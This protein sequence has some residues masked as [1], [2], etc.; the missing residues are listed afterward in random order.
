MKKNVF[1]ILFF[2]SILISAK[3]QNK[4]HIKGEFIV[5]TTENYLKKFLKSNST[6]FQIKKTIS[7]EI[8]IY[9]ISTNSILDE[10]VLLNQLHENPLIE[11]A[12]FNH[13]VQM[14]STIPNDPNYSNQWHY[15]N[16]GTNGGSIGADLDMDLAWDKAVGGNTP[17]GDTIVICVIDDGID[18]NHLDFTSNIW[19][20]HQE[21]PNNGIDDDN[22]G[23]IDDYRGWN[24]SSN[25]DSIFG[26]GHG[27]PVSGVIGAK[28]NNNEGIAGINWNVKLMIVKNDF[29]TDEA[30]VLEAYNYPLVMRKL[31]NQSNGAKGAFIVAT[32]SSWGINYG[33]PDDSPLWCAMYDSLGKYGIIS[34]GATANLN[35]DVELQNDM[36]TGCKSDFLISVT[37][38]NNADIKVTSAAYGSKSID[39]GAY[40]E[41]IYTTLFGNSY[42]SSSG[43]SIATPMVAGSIGL[44][45]AL[46]CG[47]F[48]QIS[49]DNPEKAALLV[50]NAILSSVVLNASLMGK[51]LTN[52]R[53]NVNNAVNYAVNN[54][55]NDVCLAPYSLFSTSVSDTTA[56]LH[57]NTSNDT[58]V[59][60]RYK[61]ALDSIWIEITS[62]QNYLQLSNLKPCQNYEFQVKMACPSGWSNYSA[63]ST[64][65]TEGC[66]NCLSTNY[67]NS[68]ASSSNFA[69]IDSVGF[70]SLSKM[71]LLNNGYSNFLT[72]DS[73]FYKNK[74]YLLTIK[75]GFSSIEYKAFYKA[76]IDFNQNNIFDS[77][78]L[79]FENLDG[80]SLTVSD[81]VL[82]PESALIGATRMRI[83]MQIF[84]N[85]FN[86][87]SSL[88]FGEVEDFCIGIDT[89]QKVQSVVYTEKSNIKVFPN[90][91]TNQFTISLNSKQKSNI[92][93]TDISGKILFS[94]NYYSKNISVEI[95]NN[96][97]KGVYFV[98]IELPQEVF[99]HKIIKN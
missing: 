23:Y 39:L 35:I 31:Y 60:I 7:K 76:W 82:I 1:L 21:I 48:A 26:G 14:R 56:M 65:R 43:T 38:L 27:T 73:R 5:K 97:S 58:I 6:H 17:L 22:N 2:W 55:D 12:Q 16:D 90:P 63:V 57:W 20:N 91:F 30:A 59:E 13:K 80:D 89:V 68:K 84:S 36:P 72:L 83:S 70:D 25:S 77:T 28:G 94:S 87:C 42:G 15:D 50:K 88:S 24:I 75:P 3:A 32:N 78:E 86:S 29:N 34:C 61:N 49:K 79:I 53:L 98:K 74:K 9:L 46:N 93:I 95:S 40:G 19:I 69:W 11:I 8:G 51:T 66:G 4:E 71:S 33:N 62:T 92:Q 18:T 41:N 52:G 81:S 64:F 10:Q 96:W 47:N 99:I 45:Y 67:C 85:T 54:C 44:L 37:S